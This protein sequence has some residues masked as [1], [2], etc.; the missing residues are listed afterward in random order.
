MTRALSTLF[1]ISFICFA[2]K[3]E[4]LDK[5]A[6]LLS[7]KYRQGS[8]LI[9]DCGGKYY[10]CVTESDLEKCSE[11]R[12]ID[13]DINKRKFRCIPLKK[14]STHKEC[15]EEQYRYIHREKRNPYCTNNNKRK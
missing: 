15:L 6:P 13:L 7:Y 9:Y 10:I 4:D 12:K 11:K 5:T 1:L 2:Q 14:L 3:S 8:N